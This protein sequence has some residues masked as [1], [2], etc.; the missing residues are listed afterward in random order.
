MT[1]VLGTC[2]NVGGK[3]LKMYTRLP[4]YKMVVTNQCSKNL[5]LLSRLP[6]TVY[7]S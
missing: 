5:E 7:M 6:T 2:A 3:I 1:D 4:T